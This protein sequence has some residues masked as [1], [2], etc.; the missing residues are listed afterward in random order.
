MNTKT[1][2]ATNRAKSQQETHAALVKSGAAL[3]AKNGYSGASVRD[4]SSKAGFTQG[5]FYS[6]FASK[7]DLV[8][9]IMRAQFQ[10]AYISISKIEN[11]QS[12]SPAEL[13]Q[14]ATA[15]LMDF[16]ISDEK[17]LLD[18]EIALH[19]IRD[20]KF[21]STYNELVAEHAQ[22]MVSLLQKIADA[23]ELETCAPT[24][25]VAKGMIALSR[26]L[27]L[28]APRNDQNSIRDILHVFLEAIFQQSP[29]SDT[30]QKCI[31][32]SLNA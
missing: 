11:S 8:F 5:A 4:I 15:W 16:F 30:G 21:A 27:K 31:S 22:K 25:Q 6:N 1:A 29:D 19:A 2:G 23:S 14:E 28:M 32:H 9:A 12:E 20:E 10:E 26:G 7:D 3:I 24:E 17:A 18:T 13:A